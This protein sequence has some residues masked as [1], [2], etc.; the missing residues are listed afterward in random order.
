MLFAQ[1]NAPHRDRGFVIVP[2]SGLEHRG[3]LGNRAHTNHLIHFRP[4]AGTASPTGET[5]DS[6]RAVYNIPSSGGSG[7]IAVVD[8]YDYPTAQHDFDVFSTQFHLPLS[9]DTCNNG[10]GP[11]FQVVY[12]TGS[13]PP[14]N[15]GWAQEAALDIEWAHAMAPNAQIV[16][17]EAASANLFDL[18]SAVSTVLAIWADRLPPEAVVHWNH[19]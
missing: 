1:G 19:W 8:A 7:I 2:D 15:C 17:V 3:D 9:T 10:L 11:C 16:L 5:P 14:A 18:F 6:I 13:R 4:E 12:D